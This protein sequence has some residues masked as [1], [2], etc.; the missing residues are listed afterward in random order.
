MILCA[1]VADIVDDLVGFGIGDGVGVR[2]DTMRSGRKSSFV[3]QFLG[4]VPLRFGREPCRGF[5]VSSAELLVAAAAVLLKSL[6]LQ[7]QQ[8]Y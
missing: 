3:F 2:G 5:G 6:L 1:D 8:T 4:R 7:F